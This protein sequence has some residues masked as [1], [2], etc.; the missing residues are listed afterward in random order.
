MNNSKFLGAVIT[1]L[2]FTSSLV[3]AQEAQV[4]TSS[5]EKVILYNSQPVLVDLEGDKIKSFIGEA[6]SDYMAG[7]DVTQRQVTNPSAITPI[8]KVITS[9]SFTNA[10]YAVMSNEKVHLNYKSGYATLDKAMINKLND[11]ATFLKSEPNTKVLLT[12]HLSSNTLKESKLSDN[13][14]GAATAYLKIKG[15]S[16]DRI[17][18]ETQNQSG[19]VDLIAVNYLR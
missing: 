4:S 9:E 19:L 12:S 11:I 8:Q 14:L 7:Y 1:A 6:P 18:T 17:Q 3:S 10:E 13:R 15:I 2:I 5:N 16:L